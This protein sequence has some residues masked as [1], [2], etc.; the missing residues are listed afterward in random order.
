MYSTASMFALSCCPYAW[1]SC[2]RYWMYSRANSTTP[3]D[4][5][6]S[7][8]PRKCSIRGIL[9][10]SSAL[11][12]S[13]LPASPFFDSFMMQLRSWTP[14]PLT[15]LASL[16]R[17]STSSA[18]ETP[19]TPA[20]CNTAER[21][22]TRRALSA[23]SM[24][25]LTISKTQSQ[26]ASRWA[27]SDRKCTRASTKRSLATRPMSI[28]AT[29]A[30]STSRHSRLRSWPWQVRMVYQELTRS[31]MCLSRIVSL[32]TL[33]RS[34][35]LAVCGMSLSAMSPLMASRMRRYMSM[36]GPPRERVLSRSRKKSGHRDG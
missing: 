20:L 28:Q 30:P 9:E 16:I 21:D 10:H 26:A 18:S 22:S 7:S 19:S 6:S 15:S 4:T 1:G 11:A 35:S 34:A 36:A 2:L 12:S 25:L 24:P 13:R 5:S 27:G 29:Y 32:R 33:L 3:C 23:G 31:T 14:I 17:K 8:L